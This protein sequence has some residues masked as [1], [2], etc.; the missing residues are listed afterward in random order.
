M[1]HAVSVK[2]AP[3]LTAE[4]WGYPK[5]TRPG[6]TFYWGGALRLLPG[7]PTPL[8]VDHDVSRLIGTVD[9]LFTMD[10]V[11][12]P[13]ICC[14]AVVDDPPCWLRK[15]ETKASFARWDVHSTTHADGL[16]RVTSALAKEVSLLSPATQPAEPLAGNTTMTPA[17][18]SLPDTE[19]A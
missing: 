3:V 14:R 6:R 19:S 5:W 10:W 12:G 1:T 13:W 8:V 4:R 18:K 11:D 17:V 2:L 15:Y 16:E 9:E 7:K